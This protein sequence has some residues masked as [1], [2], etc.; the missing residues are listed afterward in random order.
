MQKCGRVHLTANGGTRERERARR[1]PRLVDIQLP[2]TP[3]TAPA[4]RHVGSQMNIPLDRS[5]EPAQEHRPPHAVSR[6]PPRPHR[7]PLPATESRC[8][9]RAVGPATLAPGVGV[10]D[11]PTSRSHHHP[12]R[13]V[14]GR[15]AVAVGAADR[16][17]Q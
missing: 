11:K 3:S 16:A 8:R 1:P 5:T 15:V 9:W 4:H 13:I 14:D 7:D 2:R 17:R 6:D 10:G 12:A